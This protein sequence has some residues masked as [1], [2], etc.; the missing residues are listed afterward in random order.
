MVLQHLQSITTQEQQKHICGKHSLLWNGHTGQESCRWSDSHFWKSNQCIGRV[1][2]WTFSPTSFASTFMSASPKKSKI[3]FVPTFPP[4]ATPTPPT[5]TPYPH[6]L[7][8]TDWGFALCHV[9]P[10]VAELNVGLSRRA[11][12][13]CYGT[14]CCGPG[15]SLMRQTVR[16]LCTSVLRQAQIK[17][18]RGAPYVPLTKPLHAYETWTHTHRA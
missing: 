17:W 18:S 11:K 14:H 2:E 7:L 10:G 8:F 4:P 6:T 12:V 1:R 5:P 9:T 15:L 16:R 13:L 3:Q